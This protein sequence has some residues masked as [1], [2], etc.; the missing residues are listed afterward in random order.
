M[1]KRGIKR[2]DSKEVF[3]MWKGRIWFLINMFFSVMYLLWRIFFTI[4]FEYG[5]VSIVAGLALLVVEVLGMVEALI[6][7]ANM[8]VFVFFDVADAFF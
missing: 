8:A 1:E 2:M 5:I 4:P 3:H 6:H 7:Y